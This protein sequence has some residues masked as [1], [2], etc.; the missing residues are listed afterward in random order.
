MILCGQTK[1]TSH[2][3]CRNCSD[4]ILVVKIAYLWW[5]CVSIYDSHDAHLNSITI[6]ICPYLQQD[7]SYAAYQELGHCWAKRVTVYMWW[8]FMS[9][10]NSHDAHLNSTNIIVCPYFTAGCNLCS[11]PRI[12]TDE[13]CPTTS[14]PSVYVVVLYEQLRLTWCSSKFHQHYYLSIFTEGCNLCGLPRI[15]T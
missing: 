12:R 10:Y 14:L 1:R 7:A 15:R 9:I 2:L 6:T 8:S 4:E 3:S 13:S 5:S 11:L